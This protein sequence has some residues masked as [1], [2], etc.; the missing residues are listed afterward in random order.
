MYDTGGSSAPVPVRVVARTW[1]RTPRT[2]RAR[3][4][5]YLALGAVIGM[6]VVTSVLGSS[7][8]HPRWFGPAPRPL[9]ARPGTSAIS[10][11]FSVAVAHSDPPFDRSG[12]AN[13]RG[14]ACAEGRPA[15]S[16]SRTAASVA[17]RGDARARPGIAPKRPPDIRARRV[18]RDQF[19]ERPAASRFD[20]ISPGRRNASRGRRNCPTA[21]RRA[22]LRNNGDAPVPRRRRRETDPLTTRDERRWRP[23]QTRTR[24]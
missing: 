20:V 16:A 6:R 11:L 21:T 24:R 10:C 19:V 5:S 17:A 7:V 3:T 13:R 8:Q 12:A 22:R 14:A 18:R 9:V 4:R 1:W 15:A 2:A 23:E